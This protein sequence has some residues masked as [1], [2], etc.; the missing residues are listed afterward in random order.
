MFVCAECAPAAHASGI[1]AISLGMCERCNV[2]MPCIQIQTPAAFAFPFR[3]PGRA[4]VDHPGASPREQKLEQALRAARGFVLSLSMQEAGHVA[5]GYYL[6]LLT[7]I[8]EALEY[9]GTP[10]QPK[11]L[12]IF[13]VEGYSIEVGTYGSM[14]IARLRNSPDYTLY[15][16]C[17]VTPFEALQLLGQTIRERRPSLGLMIMLSS[18]EFVAPS[19]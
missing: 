8:R 14:S 11:E 4:I 17:G 9:P 10:A 19:V 5:D 7:V 12:T 13:P 3:E 16:A 6:S 2:V 18:H 1:Y 15:N